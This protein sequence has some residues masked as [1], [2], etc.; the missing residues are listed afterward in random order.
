MT[1]CVCSVLLGQGDCQRDTGPLHIGVQ[2][3]NGIQLAKKVHVSK[4]QVG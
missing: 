3:A 4:E 2:T 1:E